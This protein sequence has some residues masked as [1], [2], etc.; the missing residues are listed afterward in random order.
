[1]SDTYNEFLFR[2]SSKLRNDLLFAQSKTRELYNME[3]IEEFFDIKDSPIEHVAISVA[4]VSD[5]VNH[6]Y[7]YALAATNRMELNLEE[8]D[9]S[10]ILDGVLTVADQ[11][12]ENGF[13]LTIEEEIDEN[14]PAIEADAERLSQALLHY[15][16]NATKFTENG[17][18]TIR[19]KREPNNILFEVRDTGVG[20]PED[21]QELIFEPFETIL[22]DKEDPR[23]GLGLG[24]KTVEYIIDLHDGETWFESKEG[25]GSSFFF[26]I[27]IS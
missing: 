8:V 12:V 23:L 25:A 17:T 13:G 15:I 1:M 26:T 22:E 27:P 5:A 7:D 3:D 14:L 18:I 19:V 24:L 9:I 16:H 20:I 10:A 4:T 6:L 11:M 21:K 2:M